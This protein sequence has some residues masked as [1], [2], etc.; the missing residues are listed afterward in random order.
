M[1]RSDSRFS[2]A[3]GIPSPAF[4]GMLLPPML[5]ARQIR[6]RRRSPRALGLAFLAG[7]VVAGLVTTLLVD[8]AGERTQQRVR[9]FA[10]AVASRAIGAGL[11]VYDPYS[12]VSMGLPCNCSSDWPLHCSDP[13]A[14]YYDRVRADPRVAP[15][16]G[17]PPH[18]IGSYAAIMDWLRDRFPHGDYSHPSRLGSRGFH[19]LEMLDEADRG[20]RFLCGE[21]AKMFAQLVQATGGFA[22]RVSLASASGSGHVVTEAWIEEPGEAGRWVMFDPDYDV[23]F[24]DESGRPLSALDL[25]GLQRAGG[26]ARI[27]P[28]P[29]ASRNALYGP[30]LHR[31]LVD[32]Y[33]ELA[34]SARANWAVADL[35]KWHPARHPRENLY[36]WQD[37]DTI[38]PR[39]YVREIVDEPER[40][41][42]T[43][44]RPPKGADEGRPPTVGH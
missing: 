34:F 18:R 22:R 37:G 25:H 8:A 20:E 40:L 2:P 38:F 15:L 1:R 33:H 27:T 9:H 29:G 39:S 36:V 16:L 4:V 6:K 11:A 13:G 35:P 31:F 26:Y 23:W 21:I 32:H 10:S 5:D 44:C 17:S 41:Y 42:F 12:G 30:G 43:P 24:S 28:H 3:F 14:A 19:V 7:L